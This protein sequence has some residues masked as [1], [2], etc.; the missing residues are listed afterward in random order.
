MHSEGGATFETIKS[1]LPGGILD[2]IDMVSIGSAHLFS[3]PGFRSTR[4]FIAKNDVI[5]LLGSLLSLNLR[6]LFGRTVQ[7][8]PV[9]HGEGPIASH[10]FLSQTYRT[11]LDQIHTEYAAELSP[12]VYAKEEKAD[13]SKFSKVYIERSNITMTNDGLF[14]KMGEKTFPIS[15]LAIDDRGFYTKFGPGDSMRARCCGRCKKVFW[16]SESEIKDGT[17]RCF[18][19]GTR[20]RVKPLP[21]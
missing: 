20:N 4:N 3:D 17:V 19:C 16:F 2:R 10:Q 5:P 14:V 21:K 13:H 6:G 9:L 1:H 15:N 8:V 18:H 12:S 11:V 7:E